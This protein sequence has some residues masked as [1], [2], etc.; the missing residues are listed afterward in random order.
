MPLK[1]GHLLYDK[2]SQC[3]TPQD[4]LQAIGDLLDAIGNPFPDANGPVEILYH[5]IDDDTVINQNGDVITVTGGAS[6]V[7]Q[8]EG[9]PLGAF[10][11]MNFVGDGVEA[12]DGGGGV[13]IVTINGGSASFTEGDGIHISGGGVVSVDLTSPDPCLEFVGGDLQVQLAPDGGLDRD[14]DG[15]L[16]HWRYFRITGQATAANA[17]SGGSVGID[18]VTSTNGETPVA[19]SGDVITCHG[20]PLYCADNDVL[21]AVYD[22]DGGGSIDV[23]WTTD[24]LGNL[25]P[26]MCGWSGYDPT[27]NMLLGH[28]AGATESSQQAVNWKTVA[29]WL[30]TLPNYI[31]TGTWLPISIDGVVQW[32]DASE[33]GT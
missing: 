13:V 7:V 2:K 17:P 21:W 11:V 30:K 8:D 25:R 23:N 27:K 18:N 5:N 10:T 12:T 3:I 24:T 26:I 32:I 14:V 1:L 28:P 19:G 29:D 4:K 16:A 6:L 33:C 9:T 31:A 22:D 20:W 15:I